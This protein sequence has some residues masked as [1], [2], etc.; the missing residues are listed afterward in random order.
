MQHRNRPKQASANSMAETQWTTFDPE[1]P[2]SWSATDFSSFAERSRWIFAKTMPQNSH[3][4]T[5]RSDTSDS[6]FE[7]AVTYIRANGHMEMF[8]GQP[9]KALHLNGYKYWTMGAP[10]VITILIN[11]KV[12]PE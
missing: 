7:D 2:S 3:H 6:E 11:R 4:Y 12:L 1:R 8:A 5:L 10:L 9:Y